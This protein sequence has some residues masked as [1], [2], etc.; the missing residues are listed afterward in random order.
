MSSFKLSD[1]ESYYPNNVL[2]IFGYSEQATLALEIINKE[3]KD[4]FN[5]I[6]PAYFENRFIVVKNFQDDY[7]LS[8]V[9]CTNIRM[10][11][12]KL[13]YYKKDVIIQV[14]E[15]KDVIL[16]ED[17]DCSSIFDN[18]NNLIYVFNSNKEV[19]FAHKQEIDITK[20]EFGSQFSDE[21]HELEKQ[22]YNYNLHRVRHSSCPLLFDSWH[23]SNKIFFKGGGKDIPESFIQKSLHNFIK[24]LSIFKGELG[25]FD[26]TREH[27]TDA[28]KPVDII[29]RW[30]K[31]NRIALIEIKWMGKS[32]HNSEFK[33]NHNNSRA[34]EGYADLKEYFDLA[35]K[36]NPNKLIKCFLVVID[37]RRWNTNETTTTI[38]YSNGM[39]YENE[40]ITLDEDK[41]F[42]TNHKEIC[43][44]IRMFAEP[45]CS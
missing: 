10:N 3:L 18:E 12:A 32:I 30:E 17:I 9:N 7:I 31:S 41:K 22:L 45:I 11:K 24:D 23:S 37:G 42:H 35:R 20:N 15:N 26:P 16:W 36:D 33:S 38:S 27:N 13:F 29:V 19:F 43:K 25:Q 4:L 44:P 5:F 34:N 6:E 21:F 40:E 8:K 28:R 14:F 1:I 2:K 39:H